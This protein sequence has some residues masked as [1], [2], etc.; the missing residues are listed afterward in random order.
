MCHIF[1]FFKINDYEIKTFPMQA[2]FKKTGKFRILSGHK[3]ENEQ[4]KQPLENLI[5]NSIRHIFSLG[6]SLLFSTL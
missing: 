2:Y 4:L 1:Q 3:H 6:F 5:E